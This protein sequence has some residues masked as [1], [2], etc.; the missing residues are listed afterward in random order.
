MPALSAIG[1]SPVETIRLVEHFARPAP[2]V[3][4]TATSLPGHL[5]HLVVAGEVEQT[6]NGRHQR[7]RPG[8][9]VWYHEDEWVEGRILRAPWIYYSV[10]FAAPALSPPD[11]DQRLMTGRAALTKIFAALH[12]AW[13]T[14]PSRARDCLGQAHLLTL[15][16]GI[17]AHRDRGAPATPAGKL[18]WEVETWARQHIDR[19]L[20]L[21]EL[22]AHSGRSANTLA[23]ACREAVGLAPMKRLKQIRLSLARGLVRHSDLNMTEIALRIGYGRVHEFSR[24]YRKAHGAPPTA[25]RAAG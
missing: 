19:A 3:A 13:L 4:F 8:T 23:R 20:T 22:C 2:G 5:I 15:L 10:N 21:D 18:W 7:L 6:C 12:A 1:A 9:V 11:F 25:D 14:P 24:D 16:A 17:D